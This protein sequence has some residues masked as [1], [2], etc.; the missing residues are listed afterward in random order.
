MISLTVFRRIL[1]T[2]HCVA[3]EYI[4]GCGAKCPASSFVMHSGNLV[5]V[6]ATRENGV[7][8]HKCPECGLLFKSVE[9][10]FL[11]KAH[12]IGRLPISVDAKPKKRH[13]KKRER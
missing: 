7:R 12:E 6:Y 4:R 5:P 13:I 9:K 8:Y 1:Y 10:D 11:P 2:I 3:V